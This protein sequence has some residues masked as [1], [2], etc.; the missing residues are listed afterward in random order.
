MAK[1]LVEKYE[2]ILA[3]DPASTAFVELAKALIEK[4]EHQRAVSACQTGLEHHPKSVV[5]RVLWG[6]ALIHLG[7]PAEAMEQFDRAIAIDRDN[8]HA[9]NLIGEVL[10]HKGLYRS[11]LPLL[12]KAVALQPNDGRVRQWLEQTQAALAG[13]PAPVLRE[14]TP[15]APEVTDPSASTVPALGEEGEERSTDVNIAAL[16]G[17]DSSAPKPW[18]TLENPTA[19]DPFSQVPKRTAS[20]EVLGGLTATFD[21]LA[22]GHSLPGLE[23]PLEDEEPNTSPVPTV[24]P[25]DPFE[26]VGGGLPAMDDDD[27]GETI[28]LQLS[29]VVPSPSHSEPTVVPS[30]ELMQEAQAKDAAESGLFADIPALEDDVLPSTES[31]AYIP[32]VRDPAPSNGGGLLD[33]IPDLDRSTSLEQPRVQVS[34]RAAEAIA[35]EY[36]RELREK[37]AQTRAHRGFFARNWLKLS[38]SAVALAALIAGAVV[39]VMTRTANQGDLADALAAGKKGI[40]QDSAESYRAALVALERAVRMDEKSADAWAL[41]A[42]ARALVFAEHEG[43]AEDRAAAERALERPGVADNFAG[44][45][46]AVRYYVAPEAQRAERA[47]AVLES[48]LPDAEVNELAGRILLAQREPQQAL[49]RFKRALESTPTHVRS[50]V[51]LGDYYLGAGDYLNALNFYATAAQVSPRHP[52][53][54]VGAGEARLAL[55]Q[56]LEQALG[57]LEALPP[58]EQLPKPIQARRELIHGRL[59]A[60]AKRFPDAVARLGAGASVHRLQAYDFQVALADVQLAAGTLR[61]AQ[62][63][64]ELALKARPQS[65]EAQ[66]LLGRI[67]L[68]RGREAELLKRISSSGDSRKVAMV[69]GLAL[70]RQGDFKRARAEFAKTRV[71]GKYPPEAIIHLAIADAEDGQ[72]ERAVS[73]LEKALGATKKAKGEV[74][75]ALGQIHRK[76]GELDRARERYEQAA[77]EADDVEGSCALGR[78]LLDSGL[79]DQAIAPLRAAVGRNRSHREAQAALGRALLEL[80]KSDEALAAGEAWVE[81]SPDDSGA[82]LVVAWAHFVQGKVKE[83]EEASARAV[84]VGSGDVHAFRLRAQVLFAAGNAKGAF[85]A[86]ERANKLNPKDAETFCEIG[87]AFLRQG[88]KDNAQK[89]FEAARREVPD[90]PCGLLGEAEARLPQV[91]KAALAKVEDLSKGAPAVWDRAYAAAV[92]ARMRL[93]GAKGKDA[94][95]AAE[96]AVALGPS[97]AKA[98][99][100]LAAVALKEKS[101]EAAQAALEKAVALDPSDGG[102]R[103]QLADVL[104]R[105]GPEAVAKAITEYETFLD[106]GGDERDERRADQAITGPRKK[107]K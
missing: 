39:F 80:G 49:E 18:P 24:P 25:P 50:L 27:R 84:K 42:Q 68:G 91:D 22:E 86:L 4:G 102:L 76:K 30:L 55:D 93:A 1:S 107:L 52:A 100:A 97:L 98:H 73:V 23:I 99:Q 92:L 72:A 33:D 35:K 16:A 69:R 48:I 19:D 64:A 78:L 5:G 63:A 95:A 45:A 46:L 67:L 9:Y 62:E 44:V 96:E 36:E 31:P 70:S 40:A 17:V 89:A 66:A 3:Q 8:P 65:D 38:L 82:H 28:P 104:A 47:K 105:G 41:T 34:S 60:A 12:R 85:G 54:T 90:L 2:Q 26:A 53:R 13:G 61:L 57:E 14:P 75:V 6:K 77:K 59:L 103:L 106:I 11:A 83:A 71:N 7:R 74:L 56:E 79:P 58:T 43:T 15:A 10:L 51:A 94:R 32:T 20:G 21:A 88:A 81:E 101:L 37:L 29:E 87:H